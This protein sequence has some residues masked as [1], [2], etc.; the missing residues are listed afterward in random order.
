ME[1]LCFQAL[2]SERVVPREP[3]GLWRGILSCCRAA[4]FVAFERTTV[5]ACT[6]ALSTKLWYSGK[7]VHPNTHIHPLI[8]ST[9][10]A[11][12]IILSLARFVVEIWKYSQ[13][14]KKVYQ[15]HISLQSRYFRICYIA[16]LTCFQ[17]QDQSLLRTRSASTQRRTTALFYCSNLLHAL[18]GPKVKEACQVWKIYARLTAPLSPVMKLNV[19]ERGKI[20]WQQARLTWVI[21]SLSFRCLRSIIQL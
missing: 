10:F 13:V 16:D 19:K 20:I 6:E 9:P 7:G 18:R 2:W 5:R 14:M 3:T 8:Q 12:E 4:F 21:I 15:M 17:E 11:V 1:M